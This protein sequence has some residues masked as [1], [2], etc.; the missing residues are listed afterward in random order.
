MRNGWDCHDEKLHYFYTKN[1]SLIGFS[2]FYVNQHP[3]WVEFLLLSIR[4]TI[5]T[6]SVNSL[7][8]YAYPSQTN[9]KWLMPSIVFC[10]NNNKLKINFITK[11]AHR[12][13]SQ[14]FTTIHNRLFFFFFQFYLSYVKRAPPFEFI[15]TRIDQFQKY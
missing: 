8:I 13:N 2:S 3:N 4:Q 9:V 12:N 1:C 5:D 11:S 7:Y 14:L 10:F 6:S 15:H